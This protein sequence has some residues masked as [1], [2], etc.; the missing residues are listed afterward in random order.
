MKSIRIKVTQQIF[1]TEITAAM[2]NGSTRFTFWFYPETKET[3]RKKIA[4]HF[5]EHLLGRE[6]VQPVT[7]Y[8]D[9]EPKPVETAPLIYRLTPDSI[10]KMMGQ[11]KEITTS[12][13]SV[14]TYLGKQP[15]FVWAVV[16]HENEIFQQEV[17][18]MSNQ[19]LR[20]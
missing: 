9:K 18:A 3:K 6:T 4:D 14:A 7:L 5:Q 10:E 19:A 11:Y 1:L 16:F 15:S 20:P 13:D 2:Q 17:D 8:G 12:C